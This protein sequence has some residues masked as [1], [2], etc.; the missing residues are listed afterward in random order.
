MNE[1]NK[2]S[3]IVHIL[4]ALV[5]YTKKNLQLTFNPTEFFNELERT[6]GISRRTLIQTYSRAKKTKLIEG[7]RT[8]VL[9]LKG[10][11]HVQPYVAKPLD[12]TQLMVIFDIPESHGEQ[13]RQ[14]RTLLQYLGFAQAQ[15]S[16]WMSPNDHSEIL[17]D[18]IVNLSLGDWVQVYEVTRIR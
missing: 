18:T 10:R 13:R 8:P 4:I 11:Q 2:Q 17:N 15:R 6:S 7:D 12:G 3:A 5:S 14:L 1:N 9:T 16:V